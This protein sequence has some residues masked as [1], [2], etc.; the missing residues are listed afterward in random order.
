MASAMEEVSYEFG[1]LL[2]V[3]MV[4]SLFSFFYAR[5]APE[6]IAQN[7]EQGLS[8]PTLADAARA[9]IDTSYISVLVIIAITACIACAIT[10]YLLWNNPKETQFAH[11]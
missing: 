9:A 1:T 3:A 7:F 6:V 4:G 5:S 8:H 10:A 11:E 2:S